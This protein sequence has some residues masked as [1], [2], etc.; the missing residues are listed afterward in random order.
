M[1]LGAG[2]WHPEADKLALLRDDIDNNS[3]RLKD[4]LRQ[5]GLRREFFGGIPDDEDE[6][7][8]AFAKQNSE[9]ALKTKPK[10][11]ILSHS[12]SHLTPALCHSPMSLVS[13][14]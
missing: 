9:S 1:C 12:F 6:A 8:G 10:V 14:F 7:V 2:L 13:S 5:E 4:V 3:E 11:R